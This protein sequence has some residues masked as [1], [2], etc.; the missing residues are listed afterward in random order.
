M[1]EMKIL[2]VIVALV[3]ITYYGIEPYAHHVM[4][5]SPEKPLDFQFKDLKNVDMNLKGNVA[6]G[7]NQFAMNCTACH[8]LTADG[9]KA[10]MSPSDAANAFGVTPPDLSLAGRIYDKNYLA[11]FI[12]NPVQA[13]NLGHKYPTGGTKAH[14]MPAY[15]WMS[16]QNIMDI[17]AY[18]EAIA[19]KELDMAQMQTVEAEGGDSIKKQIKAQN[20]EVFESACGRCHSMQYA[21]I[22]ATTPLATVS[23]YMG[24]TPPDLSQY[25][26]SRGRHYLEYFIN[27]PQNMLHGTAMPRVGLTEKAQNQVID[28][29]EEV[30][31]GKKAERE[32][33][34]VNVIIYSVIFAIFALLWKRKIWS[35]VH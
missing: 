5:P 25:I 17:V 31:D 14:P 20:Q 12:Y 28:F 13:S 29:M 35:E 10:G 34:G 22:K 15:N 9:Y 3:G 19:P 1:K 32:A 7:K 33:L 4:H 24:S 27:D 11:N 26:K 8:S 21:G 30:G 2:A 18:M 23:K 16:Q 6:E